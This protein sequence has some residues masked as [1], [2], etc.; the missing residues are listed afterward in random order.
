MMPCSGGGGPRCLHF[1]GVC[2]CVTVYVWTLT[3]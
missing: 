3:K 1:Q 2:V